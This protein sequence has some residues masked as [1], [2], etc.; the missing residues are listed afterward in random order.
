VRR[1]KLSHSVRCANVLEEV[2]TYKEAVYMFT[3][4]L[5]ACGRRRTRKKV[6]FWKLQISF[7]WKKGAAAPYLKLPVFAAQQGRS[8]VLLLIKGLE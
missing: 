5:L 3:S 1:A 7:L 8:V 6:K 2:E 4:R